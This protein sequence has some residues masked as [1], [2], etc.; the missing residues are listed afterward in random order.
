V[1]SINTRGGAR[2]A[3]TPICH[4][5]KNSTATSSQPNPEALATCEVLAHPRVAFH[6]YTY[7]LRGGI[8]TIVVALIDYNDMEVTAGMT[9]RC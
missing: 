8:A 1:C 2:G 6:P 7:R 4:H 9:T 5:L 3:D